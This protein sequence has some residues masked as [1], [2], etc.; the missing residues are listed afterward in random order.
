M[1]SAPNL[2]SAQSASFT[3]VPQ[4]PSE[5]AAQADSFVDSIG[6]Q[7]HASYTN[8]A[9]G[10]WSQV[11]AALQSLGVRHIRDGLPVTSTF[12]SNFQQLAAAGIHCTCGFGLPNTLT[13]AQIKLRATRA[14]YRGAGS[15]Q[16]MR[17][18]AELRW[19]RPDRDR[20]S[21]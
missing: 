19:R 17:R 8:T 16:R 21:R 20:E 7:T 18:G 3:I 4:L 12:V 2:T 5:G 9:Y 15:P 11:M 13:A 6:V 1:A 14:G 10:N